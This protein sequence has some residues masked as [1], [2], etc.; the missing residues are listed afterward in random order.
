M[1]GQGVNLVRVR[2][3]EAQMILGG[4]R[5]ILSLSFDDVR[6]AAGDQSLS[7]EF[8]A[9][10][11]NRFTIEHNLQWREDLAGLVQDEKGERAR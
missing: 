5:P 2:Q 4:Q 8:C 9:E 10:V 3:G 1:S 6:G 7:D 11:L